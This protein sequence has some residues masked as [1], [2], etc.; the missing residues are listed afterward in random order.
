[1]AQLKNN[2]FVMLGSL[3]TT[4]ISAVNG[5][6][7]ITIMAGGITLLQFLA[8]KQQEVYERFFGKTDVA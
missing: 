8:W 4:V 2:R 1:M 7:F 5:L 3:A 6:S